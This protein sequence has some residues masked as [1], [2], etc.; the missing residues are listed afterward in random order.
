MAWLGRAVE[1]GID[2]LVDVAD[3]A[4]VAQLRSAW[5]GLEIPYAL[6]LDAGRSALSAEERTDVS[7]AIAELRELLDSEASREP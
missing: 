1:E 5:S 4:W 2:A 6:M 3:E 7:N